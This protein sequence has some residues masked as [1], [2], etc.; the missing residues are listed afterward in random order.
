MVFDDD[1]SEGPADPYPPGAVEPPRAAP[2]PTRR[3]PG[4]AVATPTDDDAAGLGGVEPPAP[5]AP[6]PGPDP[7]PAPEPPAAEP[8]T[9]KGAGA[10]DEAGSGGAGGEPSGNGSPAA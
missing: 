3:D 5:P 6:E 2:N 8:G 4:G 1:P 7:E 10:P 9:E